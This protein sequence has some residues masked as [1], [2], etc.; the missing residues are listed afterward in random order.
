MV[1]TCALV[2][3]IT[4]I[5]FFFS[6]LVAHS[7][8]VGH[9]QIPLWGIWEY[10]ITFAGCRQMWCRAGVGL[11]Q[12]RPGSRVALFGPY[13]FLPSSRTRPHMFRTKPMAAARRNHPEMPTRALNGSTLV[14]L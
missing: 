2:V 4:G 9:S 7:L 14:Q 1:V 10:Y 13:P 5:W 6:V 8:S 11:W 12:E 3:S